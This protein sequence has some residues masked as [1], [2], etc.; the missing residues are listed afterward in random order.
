MARILDPKELAIICPVL[1][2]LDYTKEFIKTIKSKIPY[3]LIFIDNGST[4]GTKKFLSD[5]QAKGKCLYIR[6]KG[7]DGVAK[8]WNYGI[9]LAKELYKSQ[10]Y[11]ILNNDIWLHPET[12]DIMLKTIK[13]PGV[14]LVSG[15]DI[16]G[17]VV[18]AKDVLTLDIP[19]KGELKE[20]PE[21]SCF[22]VKKGTI[23]LIG[24]FDEK[25][26]PA[27]FEDNDYHYRMR[28]KGLRAVREPQAI[29][30]HY[31]SRTIKQG[32]RVKASVNAG[33][34]INEDYF[35]QKWGGKPGK[36]RFKTPFNKK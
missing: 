16:T 19:Q 24:Y 12:L 8:A 23:E 31:G 13:T 29:Y 21:F 22:M 33:Y 36:E 18:E 2:C 32:G 28:L 11:A 4:D 1:N 30:Y 20:T 14:G 35:V 17:R 26:Y 15:A 5:L 9:Q 10:Y 7:N 25:F 6:N 34:T 3:V 27:Y